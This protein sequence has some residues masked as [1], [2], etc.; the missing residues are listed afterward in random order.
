[1]K[2]ILSKTTKRCWKKLKRGGG[3]WE[4]NRKSLWTFF[5]AIPS[6]GHS[7]CSWPIYISPSYQ[8]GQVLCVF[9]QLSKL[10][11]SYSQWGVSWSDW[12]WG[13]DERGL[14]HFPCW[15]QLAFLSLCS[16]QQWS[17]NKGQQEGAAGDFTGGP[18]AKTPSSQC[19]RAQVQFLV[20]E[21]D[22]KLRICM[23]QPMIPHAKM[24]TPAAK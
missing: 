13:R 6:T 17:W 3:G 1:M 2:W 14:C 19:R 24:K 21:L 22:P 10:G 4:Q 15:F 23:A 7:L 9:L 8:G 5:L 16:P 18:V 20:R 12:G 11:Q